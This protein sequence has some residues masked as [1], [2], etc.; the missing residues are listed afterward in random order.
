MGF[1][2][3]AARQDTEPSGS[4]AIGNRARK[5]RVDPPVVSWRVTFFFIIIY[6]YLLAFS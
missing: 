6:L 4:S 2:L 1:S 5:S 3:Q